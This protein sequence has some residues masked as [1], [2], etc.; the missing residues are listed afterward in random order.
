VHFVIVDFREIRQCDPAFFFHLGDL[1]SQ[2]ETCDGVLI[3]CGI[4][5]EIA[6][7]FAEPTQEPSGIRPHRIIAYGVDSAIDEIEQELFLRKMSRMSS[8]G[9]DRSEMREMPP[10]FPVD[11]PPVIFDKRP[12]IGALS[13]DGRAESR[14]WLKKWRNLL[15]LVSFRRRLDPVTCTVFAPPVLPQGGQGMVQVYAHHPDDT[16]ATIVSAKQFDPQSECRGFKTLETEMA[17]GTRIDFHLLMKGVLIDHP[18]QHVTWRGCPEPVQFGVRI[19]RNRRVGDLIGTIVVGQNGAPVGYIKFKLTVVPSDRRNR[20]GRPTG[21][22]ACRYETAFF[23]YA[24][25]DRREVLKR[26][27]ILRQLRIKFFYDLLSLDPGVRWERELYKHI[28]ESDLFLLFWSKAA[29]ESEWVLKEL[30]YAVECQGGDDSAPPEIMPVVLEGPPPPP[31]PRE[32]A[33][34][35]FNDFLLYLLQDS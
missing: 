9:S 34:L 26:V 20:L 10:D 27:Q 16:R 11:R 8:G 24:S 12:P 29:S 31:P 33:H 19:P 2:L 17:K 3:C 5:S 15:R 35:H 7:Y 1:E 13:T 25:S 30:R 21:E 22:K 28:K 6:A 18:V 32:L 14:S 4:S 23:S